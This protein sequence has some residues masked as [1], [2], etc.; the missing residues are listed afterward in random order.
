MAKPKKRPALVSV[1]PP[2]PA[3]PPPD[4]DDDDAPELPAPED[5]GLAELEA[6][7]AELGGISDATISVTK[8][9]L[10]GEERLHKYMAR[11]FDVDSLRDRYGGGVYWLYAHANGKLWTKR[12]V[13]FART[14][15]EQRGGTEP[16][17]S[18]PGAPVGDSALHAMIERQAQH[19]KDQMDLLLRLVTAQRPVT[20]PFQI[21]E[22]ASK[23]AAMGSNRGSDVDTLIKGMEL[24]GKYGG[25][26]GGDGGGLL[27]V[28]REFISAL[29]EGQQQSSAPTGAPGPAVAQTGEGQMQAMIRAAI[30]RQLPFLIKGAQAE[31]DPSVYAQMLLDQL[32]EIYV[33]PLVRELGKPE[34][35][36]LL[37]SINGAVVAYK[38]W[39]ESLRDEILSATSQD[40][41]PAT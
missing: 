5:G 10:Q 37:V 35:F 21:I 1:I 13:V 28:A 6:A 41:P 7:L 15:E 39:F 26:G 8:V 36:D 25:D 4:D 17:S 12:R 11:E 20:D 19:H 22:A 2:P 40:P 23:L 33:P 34:W 14:L 9:G 16:S 30:A 27:S 3:A 31:T 32:P 18:R 38:T 29:R 24:A